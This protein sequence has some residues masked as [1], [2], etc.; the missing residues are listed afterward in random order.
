MWDA[1]SGGGEGKGVE[2]K[3][4]SSGSGQIGGPRRR[5]QVGA[6]KVQGRSGLYGHLG[7]RTSP[8]KPCPVAFP[9]PSS[10]QPGMSC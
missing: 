5:F 3:A 7:C 6:R 8:R 1:A 9:D 10:P 2:A 4:A